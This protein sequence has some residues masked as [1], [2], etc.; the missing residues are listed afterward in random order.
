MSIATSFAPVAAPD[1]RIL[2]LGSM[3]GV[4]SLRAQRY[5][6]H[7]RNAF[8]PIMA[9]LLGFDVDAAYEERLQQLKRA[10][11]ALWD[12]LESCYRP[13]SLDSAIDPASQVANDFDEFFRHHP[14]I[15]LVCFN[16]GKAATTFRRQVL[17]TLQTG[18][19]RY[20]QLPSTSPAHAARSFEQKLA[21][22]RMLLDNA[23]LLHHSPSG[24]QP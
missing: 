8:W 9:A 1:A 13:G 21:Q 6:A 11:I 18:N 15:E 19:L 5:Y 22:W 14:R 10:R 16:G 3:P 24:M 20:L 7:P 2:I 17:P 12:V 23:Q 4:A